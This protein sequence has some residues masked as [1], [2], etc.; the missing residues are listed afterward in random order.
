MID[1]KLFLSEEL[2]ESADDSVASYDRQ[3]LNDCLFSDLSSPFLSV[4]AGF[5]YLRKTL[6]SYG[7]DIP[8]VFDLD[9]EGDEMLLDVSGYGAEH[10]S[11]LYVLYSLTDDGYYEFYAELTDEAGADELLKSGTEEQQEE[12]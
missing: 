6:F 8:P 11:L 12:V 4:Q 3:E 7:I 1:F 5:S 9:P 10:Q 2:V